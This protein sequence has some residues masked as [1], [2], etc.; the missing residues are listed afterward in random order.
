MKKLISILLALCVIIGMVPTGGISAQ[1]ATVGW[2]GWTP[3]GTE[4][5]LREI[6]NNLKGKYYLTNNIT[7]SS[8]WTPLAVQEG[9]RGIFD[10]NGYTISNVKLAAYSGGLDVGFFANNYGTIRNLKL[11]VDIDQ[12]VNK[13]ESSL[14]VGAV[15]GSNL[16]PRWNSIPLLSRSARSA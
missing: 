13:S 3:I 8:T 1:A 15:A 11:S 7:L 5:Q 2:D 4:A 14:N 10:G 16:V 9:F 6:D 12:A